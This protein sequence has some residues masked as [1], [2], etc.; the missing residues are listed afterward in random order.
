ML[1]R[2]SAYNRSL[3]TAPPTPMPSYVLPSVSPQPV[4]PSITPHRGP[5]PRV[6]AL[7]H[8]LPIPLHLVAGVDV[9]FGL[10][11]AL[12][13]PTTRAAPRVAA[14]HTPHARTTFIPTPACPNTPPSDC[15][16]VAPHAA[17]F[18]LLRAPACAHH[19][20]PR[21]TARVSGPLDVSVR[22]CHSFV[23]VRVVDVVF[24]STPSGHSGGRYAVAISEHIILGP[25]VP[26]IERF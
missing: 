1:Y 26:D 13:P 15:L 2:D 25:D 6:Y 14:P 9:R 23:A 16:R 8:H 19:P 11:N 12:T 4:F 7:P 18:A 17:H 10:R 22:V 20:P 5:I 3:P 24:F 21:A